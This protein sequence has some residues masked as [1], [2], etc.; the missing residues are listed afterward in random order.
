[1]PHFARKTLCD[2][3]VD[4]STGACRLVVV[5]VVEEEEEVW[6][7]RKKVGTGTYTPGG[8]GSWD[9]PVRE[10]IVMRGLQCADV[11]TCRKV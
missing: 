8:G 1:M 5:V 9:G 7:G 2:T 10:F 6:A 3:C 11:F 4:T